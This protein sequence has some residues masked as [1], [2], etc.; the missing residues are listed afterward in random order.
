M[1]QVIQTDIFNKDY[2]NGSLLE[3]L[4]FEGVDLLNGTSLLSNSF[5]SSYVFDGSKVPETDGQVINSTN[6][7]FFSQNNPITKISLI[8]KITAWVSAP[9]KTNFRVGSIGW[10]YFISPDNTFQ[11]YV[12]IWTFPKQSFEFKVLGLIKSV[13]DSGGTITNKIVGFGSG[14]ALRFSADVNYSADKTILL[15]GDSNFEASAISTNINGDT[16]LDATACVNWKTRKLYTDAGY[17]VRLIDKSISGRDSVFFNTLLTQNRLLNIKQPDLIIYNLGTNDGNATAAANNLTYFLNQITRIWPKAKIIVEAPIKAQDSAKEAL[18]QS[19]RVN[20]Q[21]I[22]S[23]LNNPYVRFIDA[24]LI[25]DGANYAKYSGTESNGSGI[26]YGVSG[27]QAWADYR[28]SR[29]IELDDTSEV[30]F[31]KM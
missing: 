2:Y 28:H 15:V 31:L 10:E 29:L 8:R 19:M 30:K 6:S 1:A 14:D 3:Q 16:S 7:T 4:Q 20:Y 13:K 18:I 11:K 17:N 22:V 24:S 5:P 9:V 12:N 21:T 27:H 23:S 26:H 25:P